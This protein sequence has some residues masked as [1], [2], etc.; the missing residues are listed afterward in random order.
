M[1]DTNGQTKIDSWKLK[2]AC[3]LS[4]G[5][6]IGWVGLFFVVAPPAIALLAESEN[7]HHDTSKIILELNHVERM[8]ESLQQDVAEIKQQISDKRYN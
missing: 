8:V 5:I 3:M 7:H 4:V 6:M 2:T 1:V